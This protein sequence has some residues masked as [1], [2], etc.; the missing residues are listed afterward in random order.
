MIVSLLPID[1][2]LEAIHRG[3]WGTAEETREIRR[4]VLAL[5]EVKRLVEVAA[6]KGMVL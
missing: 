2:S 6:K 1:E 3:E 5:L 4:I